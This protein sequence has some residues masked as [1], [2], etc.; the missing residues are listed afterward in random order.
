MTKASRGKRAWRRE[1]TLAAS[2]ALA[3][4]WPREARGARPLWVGCDRP[5]AINFWSAQQAAR[6]RAQHSRPGDIVHIESPGSI[7]LTRDAATPA[8]NVPGIPIRSTS[9]PA[10]LAAPRFR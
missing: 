10:E 2:V 4:I 6:R 9:T 5:L 8:I 1:L 3:M 7:T